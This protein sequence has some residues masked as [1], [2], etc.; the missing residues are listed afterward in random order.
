MRLRHTTSTAL[1]CALTV[2]FALAASA[3]LTIDTA[4]ITIAGTS[5]VH[6]WTASSDAVTVTEVRV[7]PGVAGANFW[8]AVLEPGALEA[9]A[10]AI[11]AASL[12]SPKEGLDKNMHKALKVKEHAEI[13]FRLLRLEPAGAPGTF[14]ATGVLR[15]TGIEKE[16][17]FPLTATRTDAA[18]TVRGEVPIVMTDFG[19]EP[20]KAMLGMLR[21]DPKVTVTFETVLAIPLT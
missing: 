3:P 5:N 6:A 2:G 8:D 7:A 12:T 15:I 9:F 21:T 20:P 11:P 17:T 19:I 4:R 16:I 1:A 10:I 18:L 14:S 13:A